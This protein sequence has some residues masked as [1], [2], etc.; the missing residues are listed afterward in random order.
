MKKEIKFP[1]KLDVN[2][3]YFKRMGRIHFNVSNIHAFFPLNKTTTFKVLHKEK[4]PKPDLLEVA[5]SLLS[6]HQ[7]LYKRQGFYD[8]TK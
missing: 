7:L 3:M 2:L 8:E 5:Y 1:T 4:N 6:P